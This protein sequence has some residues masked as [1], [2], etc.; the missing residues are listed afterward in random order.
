MK[1]FVISLSSSVE[2]R[3]S[4]SK[5][6]NGFDFTFFD[7]V[8]FTNAKHNFIFD[9]Y[10]DVGC[11]RWKGRSLTKGELGCFA[12]HALLWQECLRINEPI[13]IFE[14]N[15]EV[16]EGFSKNVNT[17]ASAIH[18]FGIIKLQ[19]FSDIQY[20]SIKEFSDDFSVVKPVTNGCGSTAYAITPEVASNYLRNMKGFIDPVDDFIGSEWRVRQPLYS[21]CP[22][23][24]YR[25]KTD[26]VIGSRRARQRLSLTNK[27]CVEVYR[28]YRKI[29][30]FI[31]NYRYLVK[32]EVSG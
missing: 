10:D 7:A 5:Q 11:R 4:V 32:G 19:N 16:A 26:S 14:D 28:G 30:R 23:L 18:E 9:F 15:I 13:F 25:R 22:P 12:S 21:C 27:A 17:V 8:D 20:V 31:Y 29:R 6:L 24:A 2:R 3:Q 1:A